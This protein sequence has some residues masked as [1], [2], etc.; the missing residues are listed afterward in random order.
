MRS[1][2][3]SGHYGDEYRPI[4]REE[5]RTRRAIARRKVGARERF[6]RAHRRLLRALLRDLL[7]LFHCATREGRGRQRASRGGRDR[8]P[9]RRRRR[10][11]FERSIE[12]IAR[13]GASPESARGGGGGARTVHE[14]VRRRVHVPRV[15]LEHRHDVV[16]ALARDAHE[17]LYLRARHRRR[18]RPS[19]PLA[20]ASKRSIEAASIADERRPRDSR[21]VRARAS[22][23]ATFTL[24]LTCERCVRLPARRGRR[25]ACGC[26]RAGARAT[27]GNYLTLTELPC[28]DREEGGKQLA[29]GNVVRVVYYLRVLRARV[30]LANDL[31]VKKRFSPILRFQHLIA[32]SF[33]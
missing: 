11:L 33:N 20:R 6:E 21:C 12:S 4:S 3:A 2:S 31:S 24:A 17:R 1:V 32:S 19:P 25:G 9:A 10:L 26:G 14:R 15:F 7:E 30:R 13:R 22:L 23:D 18:P 29:Y 8:V 5:E 28:A 16:L 27:R